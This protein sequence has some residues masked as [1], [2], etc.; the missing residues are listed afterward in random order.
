MPLYGFSVYL[1]PRCDMQSAGGNLH[2]WRVLVRLLGGRHL[3]GDVQRFL[4]SE[5]HE[6]QH[7]HAHR[8]QERV[9][10]VQQVRLHVYRRGQRQHYLQ[11]QCDLPPDLYGYLLCELR[12][13]VYL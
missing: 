8:W 9:P 3:H 12:P 4:Q 5:L 6:R 11:R 13:G 2:Q 7:M 10:H 1:S